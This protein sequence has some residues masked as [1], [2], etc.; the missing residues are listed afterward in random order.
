MR[1]AGINSRGINAEPMNGRGRYP[2]ASLLPM[3]WNTVSRVQ[4]SLLP[5]FYNVESGNSVISVLPVRWDGH[6]HVAAS[7]PV[8]YD[9][10]H[11]VG[12][13]LQVCWDTRAFV[14]RALPVRW[15]VPFAPR[16]ASRTIVGG[17]RARIARHVGESGIIR[18]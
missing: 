2:V 12:A 8:S 10:R 4:A 15:Q 7:L 3:S 17:S 1:A 13:G 5:V 9:V 18:N 16:R 11:I 14:M 6:Q